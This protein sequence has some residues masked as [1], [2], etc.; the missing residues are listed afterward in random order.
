[1]LTAT[2]VL[3]ELRRKIPGWGADVVDVPGKVLE[4]EVLTR[5]RHKRQ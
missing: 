2:M 1:M 3:H 5:M 4:W